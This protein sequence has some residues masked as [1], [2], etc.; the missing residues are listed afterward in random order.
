MYAWHYCY[1]DQ[2]NINDLQAAFGVFSFSN[3]VYTLREGSYYLLHLDTR[4]TAFTCDTVTLDPSEYFEIQQGDRVGACLK[5]NGDIDFL[6]ILQDLPSVAGN[7]FVDNWSI[8][9][10]ECTVSEM[11]VSNPISENFD[12]RSNV[13]RLYVDISKK[14]LHKQYH[15][16]ISFLDID[17]CSLNEDDCSQFATCFDIV[18]GEGSFQCT[19]STGYTGNG[20]TC[21]SN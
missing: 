18:G 4:Q 11:A 15:L 9:D 5:R 6:D 17:E 21:N 12:Q 8:G 20:T 16:L 13:L 14:M 2:N 10:G 1:N 7:F 19:C 3:Q